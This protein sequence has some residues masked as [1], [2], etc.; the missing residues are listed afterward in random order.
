M[1]EQ[2]FKP[3]WR[4]FYR[5][6]FVMV[7]CLV[8]VLVVSVKW[9]PAEYQKWLW[10][11]FIAA[12]TYTVCD[13]AYK[14]NSVLLIVKPDGI[15]LERGIIGRQSIE[16]STRNIRTIQVNQ[17]VMQRILNVGAVCVASSGTEGYEISALNMPS[18]HEI[19]QTIQTNERAV[20]K[21]AKDVKEE[22][23]HENVDNKA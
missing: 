1:N 20:A 22:E 11:L 10:L 15:A 19:R 8:V 5:H 9:L 4:C 2:K 14:R 7:I 13:M 21:K 17:S 16:I 23:E 18:P 12:I 3:A 6:F